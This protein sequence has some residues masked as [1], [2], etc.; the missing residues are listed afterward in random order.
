MNLTQQI[1]A[2]L[3][4]IAFPFHF[5]VGATA[6][7]CGGAANPNPS[8]SCCCCVG[9]DSSEL[10]EDSTCDCVAPEDSDV[11][12]K[13][14]SLKAS[15]V[16]TELAAPTWRIAKSNS[17]SFGDLRGLVPVSSLPPPDSL[18]KTFCVYLI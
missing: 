9:G 18:A 11:P 10:P 3:L 4:A 14:L 16:V 8:E 7:G 13:R 2:C 6:G 12:A 1:V 17:C 5:A 15:E